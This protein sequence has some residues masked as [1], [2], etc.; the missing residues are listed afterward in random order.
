VT[1]E[2]YAQ[3]PK[4]VREVHQQAIVY[5]LGRQHGAGQDSVSAALAFAGL[6]AQRQ[7][8]ALIHGGNMPSIADAYQTWVPQPP[9]R[10]RPVVAV[11]NDATPRERQRRRFPT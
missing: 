4:L 3:L 5:A 6:Y 10:K 8:L 2:E 1:D 7:M 11:L 9:V